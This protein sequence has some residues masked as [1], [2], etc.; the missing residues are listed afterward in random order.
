MCGGVVLCALDQNRIRPIRLF[1]PGLFAFH[2]FHFFLNSRTICSAAPSYRG[3]VVV[4]RF[5]YL[6]AVAG[7]ILLGAAYRL[8]AGIAFHDCR[9]LPGL[10]IRL[11]V[12]SH[13]QVLYV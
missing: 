1:P 8:F 13:T 11:V 6:G 5:V 2:L 4:F 10:I 9:E 7:L 12:A 3:L